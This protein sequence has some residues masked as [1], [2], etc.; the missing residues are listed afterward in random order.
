[1]SF[2]P[3][4][5]DKQLYDLYQSIFP[6]I[7]SD[8]VDGIF[9]GDAQWFGLKDNGSIVAFCTIGINNGIVFLYNVG[10]APSHRRQRYGYCLIENIIKKYGHMDIIL[11][12][13]KTNRPAINLY[14]KFNFE[15][16][17][18]K[19]VPPS[20]EICLMREKN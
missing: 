14:R 16:T 13:K 4:E 10:V 11:F 19:F 9:G 12:V 15:Y 2:S 18:G 7:P 5:F 3:I 20:G 6:E 8:E 1:M 17:D